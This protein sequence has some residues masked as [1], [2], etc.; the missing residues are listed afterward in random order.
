MNELRKAKY[1]SGDEQ[2]IRFFVDMDGTLAVFSPVHKFETL[3]EQGY[4]LSLEP[5]ENV[6]AAIKEI[7]LNYPE[8]EVNILS[9]YLV[10]SKYALVEKNDWL[11]RYLPEVEPKN[12]LFVPC[13]TD[14]KEA[15]RGGVGSSDFLLDDYTHNLVSW[16]PPARGIKL[17]N[18]INHTRGSWDGDRIRYD[19]APK[20]L[21]EALVS[22][23]RNERRILDEKIDSKFFV[24]GFEIKAKAYLANFTHRGKEHQ[25]AII[26]QG[27]DLY[28]SVG[29]KSDGDYIRH[30]LTREERAAFEAYAA[31]SNV[32]RYAGTDY[33]IYE[34]WQSADCEYAIGRFDSG[35]Y[36][37]YIARVTDKTERFSGEYFYEMGMDIDPPKR[38][39]AEDKHMDHIAERDLDLY[40]AEFEL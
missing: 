34:K 9:A 36:T 12:R 28:I 18:T 37:A 8:I 24:R 13:G 21:A 26:E 7:I 29:R 4:F 3:Y 20:D 6:V 23:M 35:D 10:D 32:I 33:S 19:R 39:K 25:S 11:D 27:D 16:Q 31:V 30:S 14:K 15:V 2:K 5:H 1:T 22:I 40:E 17:L 38:Q